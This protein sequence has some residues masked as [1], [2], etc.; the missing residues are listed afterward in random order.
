MLLYHMDDPCRNR[1]HTYL[2]QAIRLGCI[3]GDVLY[4]YRFLCP[5]ADVLLH[6][7][8]DRYILLCRIGDCRQSQS[9]ETFRYSHSRFLCLVCRRYGY[10]Q[11][12]CI[13]QS[14]VCQRDDAWRTLRPCQRYRRRQQD[15]R[16]RPR[17]CH[18]MEL[19]YQRDDDIPH[20]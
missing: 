1:F 13:C 12:K 6:L 17:L 19:R 18:R 5:P 7:Y 3:V 16:S 11:C 20:P 9:M 10:G 2:P 14:G 4:L 15:Q 8:D